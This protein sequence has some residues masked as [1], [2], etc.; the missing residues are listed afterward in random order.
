[1]RPRTGRSETRGTRERHEPTRDDFQSLRRPPTGP[2]DRRL[3][4]RARAVR[5]LLAADV[6]IGCATALLVLVQATL[7]ARVIA[8]SYSGDT[9]GELRPSLVVLLLAFGGRAGLAWA[10]EAVGRLAATSVLSRLRL[11]LAAR[12]L[13][14]EPT[15]LDGAQSAEL[16]AAGVFGATALEAYFGRFLPQLVLAAVVPAA[17]IL[18]I[19][20]IDAASAAI[21]LVTLPLVP[22]FMVLVG[23]FTAQ[24]T[25]ERAD[26]LSV[27]AT[28]FMDVVHGLPTLR[29]F[30]R[31]HVQTAAIAERSDAYRRATVSTLR[32]SFLSGAV[33]DLAATLGVALVAVSVGL[34]LDAGQMSLDPALVILILAPELYLPLRNLGALYHASADGVAV[35]SRLVPLAEPVATGRGAV[36]RPPSPRHAVVRLERV[37]YAYPGRPVPVISDVALELSPGEI[38]ALIGPTG[39]GKSTIASMLLGFAEPTAGRV[40]VGGVDLAACD[41]GS[42]RTSVAWVPQHPRLFRASVAENILLGRP[43]APLGD[44]HDAARLAGADGFI[45]GLPR[46]YDTI[47]GDGGR[48]VSAGQRQRIA[49]A[50]GFLRGASLLVLDEPTANVDSRSAGTIAGAIA[51]LRGR[52]TVLVITHA[53]DVA[54]IADRVVEVHGGRLAEG[55]RVVATA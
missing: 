7:L 30:N 35:A 9:L 29:A 25:R 8:G 48:Q 1:M 5:L 44:V 28:H 39:G 13:A 19:V 17:V 2:L 43:S 36:R 45:R 33:L 24:R 31:S 52:S 41:L 21:M 51:G 49:L 23:R 4:A 15:A 37:S 20:P 34:R 6:A 10:F 14:D 53:P 50:R 46:G 55:T 42:W 54:R 38:V 22:V 40:T 12:R 16:A 26:A 47:L 18:W 3:V 32:L 11:D 27:L